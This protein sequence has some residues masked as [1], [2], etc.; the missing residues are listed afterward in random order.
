MEQA[1]YRD[2]FAK[3]HIWHGAHKATLQQQ[4]RS[5]MVNEQDV[6][7]GWSHEPT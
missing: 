3:M 5:S 1:T 2:A 7:S 6:D 4:T